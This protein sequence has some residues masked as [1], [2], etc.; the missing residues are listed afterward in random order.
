MSENKVPKF[1][2]LMDPSVQALKRLGG[3]ASI[4]SALMGVP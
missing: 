4:F 3:S 2:A 1:D